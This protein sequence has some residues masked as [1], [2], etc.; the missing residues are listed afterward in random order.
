MKNKMKKVLITLT[1]LSLLVV[2]SVCCFASGIRETIYIYPNQVW[3]SADYHLSTRTLK[4]SYCNARNYSVYPTDGGFD[5]FS[6]IWVRVEDRYGRV[7]SEVEDL[8]DYSFGDDQV[9]ILQGFLDVEEIGF[10][11]R[12]NSNSDACADVSYDGK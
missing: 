9:D 12:G 6:T 8:V 11:F 1:V 5:T 3:D 4:Y 2:N 10:A 7:I